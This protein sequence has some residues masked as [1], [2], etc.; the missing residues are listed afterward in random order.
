MHYIRRV[1]FIGGRFHIDTLLG[2]SDGYCLIAFSIQKAVNRSL[3]STIFNP[4]DVVNAKIP[5]VNNS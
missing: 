2:V 1:E 4:S 3:Y 5:Y